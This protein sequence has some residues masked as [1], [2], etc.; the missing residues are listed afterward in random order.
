[1]LRHLLLLT[2]L[3]AVACSSTD[4]T[5]DAGTPDAAQA[6]AGNSDG[7]SSP[8][9]GDAP[10]GSHASTPPTLAEWLDADLQYGCEVYVCFFGVARS[11]SVAFC[12]DEP[13]KRALREAAVADGRL[14]FD[15]DKARACIDAL[16]PLARD[17]WGPAANLEAWDPV[18]EGVCDEV[19][20]GTVPQ[21]RPCFSDEECASGSCTVTA[22]TC[23]GKCVAPVAVGGACERT[24]MCE[25]GLSC[26]SRKCVSPG[27]QGETC[28]AAQ[29]CDSDFYCEAGT[30]RAPLTA[31]ND[32]DPDGRPCEAHLRCASGG[33]SSGTTCRERLVEGAECTR[34]GAGL[35][36]ASPDCAGNM[37]CRGLM[38]DDEGEVLFK[39]TCQTP[40]DV[41]AS[42]VPRNG[43]PGMDE[44][45]TGCLLGIDCDPETNRC[46]SLP[47]DGVACVENACNQTAFCDRGTC[48]ALLADGEPCT[49]SS[50]CR[51]VCLASTHAC[52]PAP[53]TPRCLP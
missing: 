41:D 16:E 17:C 25:T 1:M 23:P 4:E 42:C 28:S 32:C 14:T 53:V 51:N 34:P 30:C 50:E 20:R 37:V 15:A 44:A 38:L 29:P 9:G 6:D 39:G 13:E 40:G 43:N 45:S 48:R 49:T 8:D 26:V 12:G 46:R 22:Q 11:E 2:A 5:P 24:A 47:G 21:D 18:L 10:D 36:I 7:G 27:S 52:G 35:G 31:G 33:V 19:L 3:A